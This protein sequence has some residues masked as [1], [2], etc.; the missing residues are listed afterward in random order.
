MIEDMSLSELEEEFHRLVA[1]LDVEGYYKPFLTAP[2]HDGTPRIESIDGKFHFVITERGSEF[3]R[4]KDLSADDV[5]YLL[6]VGVTQ[7]VATAEEF[8]HRIEGID[9]RTV[10]FPYQERLMYELNP[11]WGARMKEQHEAILTQ[12]PFR[13]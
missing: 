13:Q 6:F 1:L 5:L 11:R 9:G 3:E 2:T 8:K 7:R 10:W 12:H 4:I